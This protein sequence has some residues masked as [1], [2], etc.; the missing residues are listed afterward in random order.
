MRQPPSA[1]ERNYP[2][3]LPTAVQMAPRYPKDWR[4]SPGVA[5]IL[6][7]NCTVTAL[8]ARRSGPYK[9]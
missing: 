7:W 8:F 4:S 5:L 2:Q 6:H 9:G 1:T 3:E